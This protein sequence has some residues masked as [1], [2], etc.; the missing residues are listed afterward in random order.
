MQKLVV[1]FEIKAVS[2]KEIEGYGSTFGN[3]D[4]GGDI[5][6]PG[7]FSRSLAAHKA[8]GT[9][10]KMLWN[11][12]TDA[13]PIGV[14]E[15]FSE[16]SHGLFLRGRFADTEMGR[17]VRTLAKMRAIDSMS[18]GYQPIDA[19]FSKDGYLLLNEVDLWEVSPVN[20]PMNP[21][22]V[23][24]A[25]KSQFGDVRSMERHLREVGCSRKAAKDL[26]HDLIGDG[27][28]PDDLDQ[29]EADDDLVRELKAREEKMLAELIQ[30]RRRI[31]I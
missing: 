1:P 4:L 22:A 5:V 31:V 7:A 27:E 3:V 23:I 15:E 21:K 6:M 30:S 9:R 24:E 29:R 2:D 10:P 25:V 26:L 18:I 16:D 11:H 28:R 19:E 8:N 20:F 14:W 17:D 13:L 12:N